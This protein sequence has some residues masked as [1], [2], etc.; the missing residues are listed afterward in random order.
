MPMVEA[1]RVIRLQGGSAYCRGVH[2]ENVWN[3][4]AAGGERL[5]WAG[6]G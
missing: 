5:F 6:C 4:N 1:G 3:G 2:F